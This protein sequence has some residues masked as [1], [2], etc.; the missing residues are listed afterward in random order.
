M[1]T[2]T[3]TIADRLPDDCIQLGT[4]VS[5]LN[6]QDQKEKWS[7]HLANGEQME[8][9]LIC[10]ALPA[11]R[12]AG[13]VKTAAPNLSES[14]ASIPYASS[15]IVNLAFRRPEIEHPPQRDGFC[16]PYS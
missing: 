16:C 4:K 14:L 12:A 5:H 3:D 6:Y 10:V 15:A 13:L 2:L 11:H 7:V 8:A 9:D 1:Q